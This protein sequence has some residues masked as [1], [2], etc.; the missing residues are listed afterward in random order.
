[1]AYKIFGFKIGPGILNDCTLLIV[2]SSALLS[3]NNFLLQ[4][5]VRKNI[6]NCKNVLLL[7]IIVW[8]G[9][10]FCNSYNILVFCA[11]VCTFT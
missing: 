7:V 9:R 10:K 6:A 5:Y 2:K 4:L 8:Y 1:M 3:E 11:C